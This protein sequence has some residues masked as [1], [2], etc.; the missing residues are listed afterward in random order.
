MFSSVK[1]KM[2]YTFSVKL[3]TLFVTNNEKKIEN[4]LT[5]ITNV[6]AENTVKL[7]FSVQREVIICLQKFSVLYL[8]LTHDL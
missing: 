4:R 7:G 6:V 2:K 8:V 5:I 3:S 1:A